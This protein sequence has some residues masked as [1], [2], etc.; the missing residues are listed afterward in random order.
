MV[1]ND[2]IQPSNVENFLE[3]IDESLLKRA[4]EYAHK[5]YLEGKCI[6]HDEVMG[7][8]KVKDDIKPWRDGNGILTMGLLDFLMNPDSLVM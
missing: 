2:E 8:I 4:A 6:P 1:K 3:G 5:Q 7:K